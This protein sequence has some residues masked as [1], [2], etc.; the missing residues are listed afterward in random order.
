M[1]AYT[2][3]LARLA[4]TLSLVRRSSR[5]RDLGLAPAA[6]ALGAEATASMASDPH[7][8]MLRRLEV[9]L[10]ERR[11]LRSERE[12]LSDDK[13]AAERAVESKRDELRRLPQ[14]L[15]GVLAAAQPVVEYFNFSDGGAGG[16]VE[17]EADASTFLPT[18]LYLLYWCLHDYRA[19]SEDPYDVTVTGDV[20][21][22]Q[23]PAVLKQW[24]THSTRAAAAT[25]SSA[26]AAAAPGE[27]DAMQVDDE[28]E[29]NGKAAR[30]G[31]R[32]ASA[33]EAQDESGDAARER[34][35]R[36]H[37]LSVQLDLR[38]SG[39][40]TL[41]FS[42]LLELRV[43]TVMTVGIRDAESP[44]HYL[45]PDD[46]GASL[47]TEGSALR[48]EKLGLVGPWVEHAAELGRPYKW[49]Q[50]IAGCAVDGGVVGASV[51]AR[52]RRSNMV[53]VVHDLAEFARLTASLASQLE[54]L[55]KREIVVPSEVERALF[56]LP[57]KAV[58]TAWARAADDGETARYAA[59]FTRG[60]DT[61]KVDVTVS[62]AYPRVPPRF[63]ITEVT[64]SS[65]V[66]GAGDARDPNLGAMEREVNAHVDELTA[67]AD[68]SLLLT[69]QLRRLQMCFDVYVVVPPQ[70]APLFILSLLPS[71]GWWQ[72]GKRI[73]A[74]CHVEFVSAATD[75]HPALARMVRGGNQLCVC[76]L[77]QLHF[78]AHT[79]TLPIAFVE[80]DT[81]SVRRST[82][83][84][85]ALGA[86]CSSGV[87]V[88]RL[89][90]ARLPS[91][92]SLVFL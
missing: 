18:P 72:V 58:L 2:H 79:H 30:R 16:M 88:A 14:L 4:F 43:V 50:L 19:L 70:P 42:Y 53:K 62:K 25:T 83:A 84:R 23:D 31:G 46:T 75:R 3:R 47:P 61:L 77:A 44:L 38:G 1:Y 34:L 27:G 66:S 28:E 68:P 57:P 54:S 8:L 22:A 33:E 49:A 17:G 81:A 37:P 92:K 12:R 36:T 24:E 29:A 73:F 48:A 63:T 13:S 71:H 67:T 56:P 74:S 26:S 41:R 64:S 91:A 55:S 76:P 10:D 7:K 89:L 20:K 40:L 65:A 45:C 9:E 11:R 80:I 82:K 69:L 39:G 21:A 32:G 60:A 90:F 5:H 78:C 15:Q 59:T 52:Q 6:E 85:T 35:L 87:C 86:N 51:E